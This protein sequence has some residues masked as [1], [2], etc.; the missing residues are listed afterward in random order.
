MAD[1]NGGRKRKISDGGLGV[2]KRG[3]GLNTGPVGNK[4]GYAGK[5][6]SSS[7]SGSSGGKG[8]SQ[9]QQSS[10]GQRAQKSGG[11]NPTILIVIAVVL[12]L[13]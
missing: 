12:L 8:P 11:F 2:H 5:P 3:E 9:P 1:P 7:S 10:G 4:E 6:G 13:G